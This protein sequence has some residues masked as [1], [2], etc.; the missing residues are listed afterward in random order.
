MSCTI[1]V[2]DV[3][4]L[5]GEHMADTLKFH[6]YQVAVTVVFV[7]GMDRSYCGCPIQK[8]SLH[9]LNISIKHS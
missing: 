7:N 2:A 4:R 8:E 6:G 3:D 5:L 1:L 9:S